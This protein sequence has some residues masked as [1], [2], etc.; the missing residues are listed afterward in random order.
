MTPHPGLK[1]SALPLEAAGTKLPWTSWACLLLAGGV[2]LFP[3]SYAWS[4]LESYSF[5]WWVPPLALLVFSERWTTRPA[6]APPSRSPGILRF[7]L[8][9]AVLFL[10][11][12]MAL[13]SSLSSRPLLWCCAILYVC[14]LLYWMW[15]YGG[16]AWTRHFAFPICFLLISVPWPA[17]IEDPIVQGL[18]Q[19]NAWLVAH[20]LVIGGIYAQAMGNVIVLAHCTLGVEAACSGIRSL[21][22]ALMIAFLLGEFYRFAWPR[23]GK[24]ILFALTMA[25]VGNFI[26]ALFLSLMA[27][28]YGVTVMSRWHDSAGFFILIFT[29]LTTWFLCAYLNRRAPQNPPATSATSSQ[30][31]SPSQ[32]VLAQRLACGILLT[33]V[34]I[35]I[36][37]Q[38]WYDWREHG[39]PHYPTW[40]A[41]FPTSGKF[42][43]MP[44]AEES[45]DILKYDAGRDVQWTDN[46]NWNWSTYWFRYHPKPTGETVF[47]AHNPDICLPAAGFVKVANYDSF[48]TEIRGIRLQVYPRQFSW[49]G[50]PAYVFWVVYADRASFPMEKA[51]TSSK[52]GPIAKARVYLSNMWHGRRASTSEMESLETIIAGPENYSAA[53]TAYLAELQKIIVPDTGQVAAATQ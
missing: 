2:I 25:L 35:T 32:A 11:F 38:G 30:P 49:N 7:I 43:E 8:I 36:A 50:I 10:F 14:A 28:F 5:G 22:A 45:H 1:G 31:W 16:A 33:A 46:Q 17:Q 52:A 26:R 9:W 15:T 42:K 21:Q 6:P 20:V 12:R 29:S 47:Q 34:L 39:E 27:S 51:I 41:S 23:R 44:I 13:E 48:A 24:I 4:Y 3:L 19:F 40:T 53:Q 37:T 18:Q